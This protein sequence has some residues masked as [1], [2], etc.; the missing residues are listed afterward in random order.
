MANKGYE[1]ENYLEFLVRQQENIL[2]GNNTSN[3]SGSLS[4]DVKKCCDAVVQKFMTGGKLGDISL[5][6]FTLKDYKNT[7]KVSGK[8]KADFVIQ[9]G[10]NTYNTSLKFGESYQL[11]SAGVSKSSEIFYNAINDTFTSSRDVNSAYQNAS[12]IT[13]Y[14][15]V[16][17]KQ[18]SGLKTTTKQNVTS[19]LNKY[20]NSSKSPGSL[21][22]QIFNNKISSMVDFYYEMKLNI[23]EEVLT[24]KE[25]T[26]ANH[27]EYI[28][29]LVTPTNI[30]FKKI[31]KSYVKEIADKIKLR[32]SAKSR[33]G[34]KQEISFRFE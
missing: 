31:D 4:Q 7:K 34:G 11:S 1:A 3:F 10:A 30:I 23:I 14:I 18:L 24:G 33:S 15:L 6:T 9:N 29:N 17:D 20:V 2:T 16:I 19:A 13:P 25:T 22:K 32:I 28:L 27:A 21:I 12:L 8:N 26:Q 5:T